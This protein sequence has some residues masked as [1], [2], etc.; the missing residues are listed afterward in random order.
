MDKEYKEEKTQDDELQPGDKVEE[1]MAL[2][3]DI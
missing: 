1:R 2:Q 3:P